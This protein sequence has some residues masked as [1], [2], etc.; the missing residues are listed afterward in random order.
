MKYI[1][2]FLEH[3]TSASGEDLVSLLN[4]N[5]RL[6]SYD[7]GSNLTAARSMAKMHARIRKVGSAGSIKEGVYEE[8]IVWSMQGNIILIEEDDNG[9]RKVIEEFNPDNL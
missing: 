6:V 5:A 3:V 2:Q 4:G 9:K 1:E 8:S 7:Y